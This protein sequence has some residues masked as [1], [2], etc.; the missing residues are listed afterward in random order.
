MTPSR[1]GRATI[2]TD[3]PGACVS[4]T[5]WRFKASEYCRR[6]VAPG[7]CLVYLIRHPL[8]ISLNAALRQALLTERLRT[9][10]GRRAE[11]FTLIR[12]LIDE[13]RLVPEDGRLRIELHGEL[14]G[15][16]ALAADTKKPG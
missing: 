10:L 16:L 5:I 9:T 4:A 11:T 3:A 6:F 13:I 15:I 7:C 14:A 2:D 1:S 8:I 12:S